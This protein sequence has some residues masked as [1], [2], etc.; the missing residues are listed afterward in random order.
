[1]NSR[2]RAILV[3]MILGDAY[4]QKTGKKNARLRLEHSEKQKDYLLWKGL[5]FSEFFQGKPKKLVRFNPV[6]KKEY[7]Y[8]RWQSNA[9]P[10]IGKFRQIFYPNNR[11]IIPKELSKLLV[12]PLSLAVWFMDDGYYYGRDKIAYLYIPRYRQE[13]LEILLN[14]LKSNFSLETKAK[15]KKRGNLVLVFNV[16]ETQKLLLLIKPFVIPSL[17]YKTSSFDPLSTAA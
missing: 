16:K 5:Q 4:L 14:T 13:E 9:S 8:F 12:S 7:G 10:E 6:Y 11:K 15:V 1:M 2:K 17:S 3:G